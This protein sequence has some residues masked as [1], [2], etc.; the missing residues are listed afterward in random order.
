MP[1]ELKEVA[2]PERAALLHAVA[3]L[4]ALGPSLLFPHQSAV[5]GAPALRELRPRGGRSPWRAFYRQ[6]KDAF[7]VAAIG[8]EALIDPRAFDRAV[9]A[10]VS[11]LDAI[12]ED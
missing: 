4:E 3:K 2:A 5:R 8:P 1:R 7:I 12:E 6:H 10:A 11:R 9:R